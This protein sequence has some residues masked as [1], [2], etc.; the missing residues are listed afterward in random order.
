V[1]AGKIL[2]VLLASWQGAYQESTFP[3]LAGKWAVAPMPSFDG[4]PASGV[5]GG[6]SY[7][8]NKDSGDIDADVEFATWM[9]SNADA[10][11]ARMGDGTSSAYVVNAE[12]REV[13]KSSFKTD[14]YAGQ[15]LYAVFEK[16]AS[17]LQPVTFGP[18]QLSLNASLADSLKSFGHGGRLTA[19]VSAA[20]QAAKAEMSS[21]GLNVQD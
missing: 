3:D 20:E 21:L 14:Y 19:A 18:T 9:T 6:S 17:G 13:A 16:S 5:L 1:A 11:K 4:Q 2:T 10:I 8:I 15:D 7:A 12:A